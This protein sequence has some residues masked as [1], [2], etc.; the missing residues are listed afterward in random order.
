MVRFLENVA[1]AVGYSAC[2]PRLN[3][4]HELVGWIHPKVVGW[5]SAGGEGRTYH[6]KTEMQIR[7]SSRDD[8]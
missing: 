1:F 4:E 2:E 7:V 8:F 3:T 6:Q 5:Q